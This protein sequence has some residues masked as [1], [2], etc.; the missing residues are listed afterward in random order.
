MKAP[1]SKA[2]DCTLHRHLA[3]LAV[4][5]HLFMREKDAIKKLSNMGIESVEGLLLY[6]ND[7][8][9]DVYILDPWWVDKA[10]KILEKIR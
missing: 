3:Q 1:L 9:V 6:A 7:S 4:T 10:S 5:H 8:G 2:S